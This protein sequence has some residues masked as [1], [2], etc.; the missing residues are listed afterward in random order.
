MEKK[1]NQ[2]GG[3]LTFAAALLALLALSACSKVYV[4]QAGLRDYRALTCF[5][6]S[7][8]QA[9]KPASCEVS[10]VVSDGKNIIMG[11][12][13]DMP[14]ADSS[15]LVM[16]EA[17]ELLG[18]LKHPLFS[19]IR[20]IEA[21]SRSTDGKWL[22]V[23]S[24]FSYYEP[25]KAWNN[26]HS[27]LIAWPADDPAKAQLLAP[28]LVDGEESSITL[29]DAMRKALKSEKWPDGPPYFKVEGMTLTSDNK[30]LFGVREQG[31]T[32]EDFEYTRTIL[33]MDYTIEDGLFKVSG[34]ISKV[35]DLLVPPIPGVEVLPALS[36]LAFDAKHNILYMLGS[37]EGPKAPCPWSDTENGLGG[38]LFWLPYNEL[39]A[40]AVLRHD[41][42]EE[43]KFNHKSEGVALLPDGKLI[44]VHDDDRDLGKN[45]KRALNQS[46]FEIIELK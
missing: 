28:T 13:K 19:R 37:F 24:G 17:G 26:R 36:D 18:S 1:I 23:S 5:N 10:A 9:E 2:L 21:L 11:S 25:T 42:L 30:I 34:E 33:A 8:S 6:E 7:F 20:K 38:L 39:K 46:L 3:V 44:V 32:W 14:E 27:M 41:G 12:D 29:N 22:V 31:A 45:W 16:N 35:A 40:G 4:P 43:L 15:L